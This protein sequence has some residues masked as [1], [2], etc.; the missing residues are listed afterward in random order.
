MNTTE[1]PASLYEALILAGIE[2]ENHESNLYFPRTEQ[3]LAILKQFP[4][5]KANAE[6]FTNQAT[7]HKGEAWIDVPFAYKPF[8][9]KVNER[10]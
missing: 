9:D 1:Q 3:T 7:P 5:Q 10:K 6:T 8:W 4:L 2:V